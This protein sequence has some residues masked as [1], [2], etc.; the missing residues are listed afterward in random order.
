MN[1]V[2][3]DTSFPKMVLLF[4]SIH[5]AHWQTAYP[6]TAAAAPFCMLHCRAGSTPNKCSDASSVPRMGQP[7]YITAACHEVSLQATLLLWQQLVLSFVPCI[8]SS[9][10]SLHAAPLYQH[11]ML[12]QCS[13]LLPACCRVQVCL[14]A[15]TGAAAAA[16]IFTKPTSKAILPGCSGA[17]AALAASSFLCHCA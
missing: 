2:H 10:R 13:A 7:A 1:K 14:P 5:A 15:N 3:I 16:A 6:A 9:L 17:C 4:F 12:V 11:Q 8:F